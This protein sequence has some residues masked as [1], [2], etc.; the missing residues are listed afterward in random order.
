VLF[1]ALLAGVTQTQFFRD[2]LRSAALSNLQAL[3]D[4]DISLGELHGNLVTGFSIDSIAVRF[5]GSDVVRAERVDLRYS[6]LEI[7]GRMISIRG[8]SI[9]HPVINLV[10]PVGEQWNIIRMLKPSPPDTIPSRPFDWVLQID[11]LEIQGGVLSLVDSASLTDPDHLKGDTSEV[12]YHDI[13][14]KEINLVLSAELRG[15]EKHLGISSM[16]FVSERPGI[17]LKKLAGDFTVTPTEARVKALTIVTDHSEIRLDADMKKFDLFGGLTLPAMEKCPVNL[18]LQAQ[19]INFEEMKRFLPDLSFLHGPVAVNLAA[20]GEFGDLLVKTLDVRF[21]HSEVRMKGSIQELHDPRNLYLDVQLFESKIDP[22]DPLALMPTFSLPDLNGMGTLRMAMHFQGRPT[23]FRTKGNVETDGGGFES[24]MSLAIGGP[25]TLHYQ[26]TVNFR[27][28][29]L[30]KLLD[31][32]SLDSRLTGGM[33]IDG[34]GVTLAALNSNML[35]DLDSSMF[36]GQPLRDTHVNISG[37]DGSL[38]G[39]AYVRLGSMS[40][41]LGLGIKQDQSGPPAF[42]IEGDVRTLHV[43]SFLMDPDNDHITTFRFR[44]K[45]SGS[46]LQ[47]VGG[48]LDLDYTYWQETDSTSTPGTLHL[49]IDQ[50]DPSN[51]NLHLESTWAR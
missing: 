37:S 5:H 43:G 48:Q 13:S 34:E 19:D 7:P 33:R 39:K 29:D 28:L 20:S 12:E 24:D 31:D 27:N 41:T 42:Q 15:K 44:A 3:L 16:S 30:S 1:L 47:T 36:R 21:A 35:L 50:S 22:A 23:D 40:S 26:G 17:R 32:E 6:L 10:R 25:A 9:I 51:R 45:G 46:S 2:R 11:R 4:A 49:D 14:L 38:Q 8:L 18:S